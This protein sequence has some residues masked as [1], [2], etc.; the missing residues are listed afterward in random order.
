MREA[1][2]LIILTVNKRLASAPLDGVFINVMPS[3]TGNT[4]N[5]Q[6][7]YHTTLCT[8]LHVINKMEFI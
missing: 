5:S 2:T 4:P 1:P 6:V 7:Y 3:T 8:H